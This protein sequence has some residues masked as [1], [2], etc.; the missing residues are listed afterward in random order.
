MTGSGD[1]GQGGAGDQRAAGA[2]PDRVLRASD[3]DREATATT[4][5]EHCGEGRLALDELSWRLEATF[6]A[7]TRGELD[8]VLADLPTVSRPAAPEVPPRRKASWTVSILGSSSR[9]GRRRL[10]RSARV[11]T[12]LGSCELDLRG[13]EVE[14]PELVVTAVALLGSVDITVPDGI[15]VELSGIPVL[16][17][18]Q[19][20]LRDVP[21][22]PGA[23]RVRVRAV[24]VLG[25][26][27]VGSRRSRRAD[28]Q[29]M[30]GATRRQVGTR[31]GHR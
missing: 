9:R 17:S 22:T 6:A 10:G 11:V 28:D 15:E 16:G 23:P 5:R 24:P 18:S 13:A 21:T 19:A 7:R 20:H 1:A 2:P 14:G 31:H 25:S 30:L 26:V 12:V 4:L 3:A 8:Q 27:D 29:G